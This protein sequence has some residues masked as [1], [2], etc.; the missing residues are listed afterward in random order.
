MIVWEDGDGSV[1]G[2]GFGGE[3]AN[4]VVLVLV[5]VVGDGVLLMDSLMGS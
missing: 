5:T 3:I 2:F 4:V 1:G